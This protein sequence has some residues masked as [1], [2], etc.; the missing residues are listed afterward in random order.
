MEG[1]MACLGHRIRMRIYGEEGVLVLVV[2]GLL[3]DVFK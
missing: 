1:N 2:R 3:G